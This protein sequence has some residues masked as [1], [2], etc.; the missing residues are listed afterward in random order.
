M[1]TNVTAKRTCGASSVAVS[2]AGALGAA[3]FTAV[4][5]GGSG[6]RAECSSNLTSCV[7]ADLRCGEV[8]NVS[9]M[10]VDAT[11]SSL[12][13]RAVALATGDWHAFS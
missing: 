12:M 2:W 11:C 3:N 8:Y 1:P 4:A 10:A 9:V 7:M 13:S 6:H 5:L